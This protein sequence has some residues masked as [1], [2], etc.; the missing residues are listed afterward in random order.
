[1]GKTAGIG[2]KNVLVAACAF[3][4]VLLARSVGAGSRDARRAQPLVGLTMPSHLA[5]IASEQS[6]TIVEM[7]VQAGQRVKVGDVLFG[8]SRRLQ[9]LEVERLESQLGSNLD[10]DRAEANLDHANQKAERERELL[11]QEISAES[12]AS[13]VEL[14]TQLASLSVREAEF[15]REQLRNEFAK[16]KELLDQRVLRSPMDGV[17]TRRFKQLGEAAD[18]LEPVVEVMSLDPLWI[19]FECPLTD[20]ADYSIGGRVRVAPAVGNAEPRVA[21]IEHI[22]LQAAVAGQTFSIRASVPNPD[23]SWRAGLKMLIEPMP[24]DVAAPPE[25]K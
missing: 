3:G 22:S 12:K 23:Y 1:M 4:V 8:L 14:E 9:Q 5:A 21:V 25:G 18:Q 19:Q 16:A 15:N 2:A 7:P 17:L 20:E 6:G 13:E 11:A 24:G 10:R